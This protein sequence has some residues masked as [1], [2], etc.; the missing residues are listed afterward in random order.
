MS[1]LGQDFDNVFEPRS[2]KEGEYQLKVLDCS[3][4]ESQKTGGH[5]VSA[6]LEIIGEP[7]AKDIN[8]VMMMPT[9]LDDIKQRNKRL[10]RIKEFLNACGYDPASID[11]VQDLIGVTCWAILTEEQ[12]PEYGMQN[13]VRKFVVGR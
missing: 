2:V 10:S 13:R 3:I 7:E 4:K 6:K 1:F 9:P 5:Y 11:N 12:D 8:H